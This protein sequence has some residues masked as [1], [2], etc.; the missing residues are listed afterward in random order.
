PTAVTHEKLK[1][2]N[3]TAVK[4]K[5]IWAENIRDNWDSIKIVLSEDNVKDEIKISNSLTVQAKVNLGSLTPDDISV[6]IY[7]GYLDSRQVVSEQEVDEMR[8]VSKEGDLHIYEGK[9]LTD[10][11]G[12]CGYTIRVL[13]QYSGEV[14]YITEMV[15]WQ[16]N[17]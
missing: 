5:A 15:K 1:K 14:Q 9:I 3:F 16:Q 12:H 6:Q 13:P 10:K 7:S 8:L 2:D 17:I 11:V 4:K